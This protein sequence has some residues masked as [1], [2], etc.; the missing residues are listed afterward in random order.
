MFLTFCKGKIHRATVTGA[1]LDYEGSIT[2]DEYLVNAAG[3]FEGQQVHINNLS[4]GKHWETYVLRGE[5]G[6]GEICLNGP[7]AHLFKKGD[8]VII[9]AYVQVHDSEAV[10]M[11][12]TTVFVD[13][14]NQLIGVKP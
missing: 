2:I 1:E 9:L 4:N 6:E 8:L 10:D 11:K 7:P 14:K 5:P 3:F 12:P 13:S